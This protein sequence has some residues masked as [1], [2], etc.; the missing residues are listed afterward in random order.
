MNR[1]VAALDVPVYSIFRGKL[2][3]IDHMLEQEGRLINILSCEDVWTKIRFVKRDKNRRPDNKPRA[4]L[5]DIINH[6]EE[7]IRIEL[8]SPKK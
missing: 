6:I 7:I 8:V 4:A 5:E 3:A 2:G 1:E